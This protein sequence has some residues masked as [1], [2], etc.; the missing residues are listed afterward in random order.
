MNI[1]HRQKQEI[2]NENKYLCFKSHSKIKIKHSSEFNS[3]E[4]NVILFCANE[5]VV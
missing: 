5:H 4:N 2:M 3:I 1:N